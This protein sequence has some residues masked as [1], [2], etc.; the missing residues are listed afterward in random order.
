MQHSSSGRFPRLGMGSS[1]EDLNEALWVLQRQRCTNPKSTAW[2]DLEMHHSNM[3]PTAI[4]MEDI[5]YNDLPLSQLSTGMKE[6]LRESKSA[7][8]LRMARLVWQDRNKN[9]PDWVLI[10][11]RSERMHGECPRTNGRDFSRTQK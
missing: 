7:K 3:D 11:T 10:V 1:Q 6:I 4:G 5:D 8:K 2:V 9:Q